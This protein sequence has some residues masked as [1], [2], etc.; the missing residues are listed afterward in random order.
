MN[1][2]L[3]LDDLVTWTDT[4]GQAVLFSKKTGSF[5]GLNPTAAYL[6]RGLLEGD[7]AATVRAA[8][9]D[10]GVEEATIASDLEDVVKTLV[11]KGLAARIDFPAEP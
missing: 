1:F 4:N 3:K 5:F 7:F 10:F 9:K 11:G 6:V 2:K 8:S